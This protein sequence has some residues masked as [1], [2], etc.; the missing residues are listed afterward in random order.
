MVSYRSAVIDLDWVPDDAPVVIVHNDDSLNRRHVTHAATIHVGEGVNVGFGR[1]VNP[2]M[3]HVITSR[4][5]L[6]NPDT[7][8]TGAH[9]RPLTSGG[10]HDLVVVPLVDGDGVPTSI[11]N[12]YPTPATL[13]LTALRVGRILGRDSAVRTALLPLLGEWGRRHHQSLIASQEARTWSAVTHWASAAA[14]SYPTELLRRV[15]GFDP[16][17]FL[18]LEDIDLVRRMAAADPE[19]RV[20][21]PEVPPGVHLVASSS[22]GRAG[23][24]RA[25]VEQA[26][27]A[28]RYARS[29]AGTAWHLVAVATGILARVSSANPRCL[30]AVSSIDNNAHILYEAD[31]PSDCGISVVR[32]NRG[33]PSTLPYSEC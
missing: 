33:P 26:R 1:A 15:N 2:A 17:Y 10:C 22:R 32:V 21:Q 23:R 27:S 8:L 16:G 3:A 7:I 19:L 18:Y 25:D 5:V 30:T 14:C 20:I 31:W 11:V 12:Q 6:V 13:L 4:V 9:W 28:E 29:Q 24:R